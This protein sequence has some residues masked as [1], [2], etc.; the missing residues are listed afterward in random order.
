MGEDVGPFLAKCS[1]SRCIAQQPRQR[2]LPVEKR[3][4]AQILA[5][6][7]DQ[8]EGVEN[9]GSCCLSPAQLLEP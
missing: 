9:R 8:V 7:L 2:S 1:F 5:V 4:L 6:V 3:K